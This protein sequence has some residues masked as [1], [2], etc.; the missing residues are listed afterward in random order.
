MI[1]RAMM[2]AITVLALS[3]ALAVPSQAA[4]SP[5]D[6]AS[7]KQVKQ[8]TRDLLQSI[9][10]YGAAQRDEAIQEIEIA[11]VRLDNRVDSLQSRI[12][13]EWDDMTAPAR[14]QARESLD[15]LQQ[16]RVE[17][18]EWYG[19]LKGSSAAAWDEIRRGFSRAYSDINQA[20]EKALNEFS[21]DNS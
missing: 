11:I 12:D 1:Y 10:S 19:Q 14:K 9:K 20:W 16:Q 21:A 5:G 6:E 17:L 18:A 3:L 8:E 7:I 4:L 13:N 2:K 15:T